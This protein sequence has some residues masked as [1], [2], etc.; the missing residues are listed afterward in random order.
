MLSLIAW[1]TDLTLTVF[2]LIWRL[3]A[4]RLPPFLRDFAVIEVTLLI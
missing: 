4:S 3:T 1:R 2:W